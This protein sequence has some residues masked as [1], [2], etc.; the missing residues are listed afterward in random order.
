MKR[1]CLEGVNELCLRKN[2]NDTRLYNIDVADSEPESG[3]FKPDIPQNA[4]QKGHT[5]EKSKI[6]PQIP[7][8]NFSKT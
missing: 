4:V 1:I 2:A 3:E 6:I 7:T 5:G 8:R